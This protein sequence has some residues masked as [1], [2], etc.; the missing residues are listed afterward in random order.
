MDSFNA[1]KINILEQL[2]AYN[3]DNLDDY[4]INLN[5]TLSEQKQLN[6]I[7]KNKNHTENITYVE[8]FISRN[9]NQIEYQLDEIKRITEQINQV[10]LE[11]DSLENEKEEY[12]KL[13]NSPECQDIAHKLS[14][15]KKTKETMKS[16]LVKKGIYLSP[17]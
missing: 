14:E 4:L 8:N 3:S 10:C 9:K 11:N 17:H 16:F 1:N 5:N 6:E 2:A 13:V 7:L 15:I 12:K